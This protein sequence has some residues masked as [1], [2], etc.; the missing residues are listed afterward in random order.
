MALYTTSINSVALSTSNDTRTIVTTATGAGS[1]VRV[2]EASLSGEASSSTVTA[3]AV[4][5]PGTAGITPG[6]AATLNKI[7]P[8]SANSS[9]TVATTWSTQPVLSTADVIV[10][11]FNAFGGGYKW[12]AFPGSE[13]VVGSQ[14]AVANLSFRSR[15]G[16]PTV[17]G[18]II[19]EER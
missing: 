17:S 3:V 18:H 4:N 19:F 1:V 13:I 12:T 14:G 9:V 15:T 2:L 6:G 10:L 16:T 5:R 11:A 7:D 8:A